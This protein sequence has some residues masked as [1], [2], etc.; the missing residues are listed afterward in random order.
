MVPSESL[1]EPLSKLQERPPQLAEM[2][3]I[4]ATL[5]GGVESSATSATE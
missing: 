3:A 4:G 1:L 2:R 5:G